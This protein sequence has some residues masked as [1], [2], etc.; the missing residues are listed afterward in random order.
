M[1]PYMWSPTYSTSEPEP[2]SSISWSSFQ[3]PLWKILP[4]RCRK[5]GP[6]TS[7]TGFPTKLW[8]VPMFVPASTRSMSLRPS[9]RN[10]GL[11]APTTTTSNKSTQSLSFTS[12]PTK[13]FMTT[14]V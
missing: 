14:F 1:S 6:P 11:P 9:P 10:A 13:K 2:T 8:S 5:A 3:V 7:L 12:F 4:S